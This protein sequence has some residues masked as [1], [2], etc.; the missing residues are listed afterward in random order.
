M[1]NTVKNYDNL[2]KEDLVVLL[3]ATNRTADIFQRRITERSEVIYEIAKYVG[4]N[5]CEYIYGLDDKGNSPLLDKMKNWFD[6]SGDKAKLKKKVEEL[7]NE[8][9]VLKKYIK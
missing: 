9:E 3:R 4:V 1:N 5:D 8:I 2:S 7:E 6:N